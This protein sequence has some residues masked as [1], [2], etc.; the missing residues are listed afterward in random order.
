[1]Q[2]KNT[3]IIVALSLL[4]APFALAMR[5]VDRFFDEVQPLLRSK[6]WSCHGAEKQKGD[7]RLD[8]IQAIRTGGE[9]GPAFFVG[10]PARSLMIQA[11]RHI[12]DDLEMPPKEPLTESQIRT[13]EEW[14]LEGAAWPAPVR[15]LFEDEPE[16]VS[17]LDEDRGTG[18]L[19]TKDVF[20]GRAALRTGKQL[21]SRNIPGWRFSIREN[22]AGGEYRYI[23]FAWKKRG[24]G[25]LIFEIPNDG[26]WRLQ[27]QTNGAWVAGKN[28]SEWGAIQISETAP[29]EW[30]VVTRDLW[31][32][33]GDWKDFTFTGMSISTLDGGEALIDS[34]ILGPTVESLDAYHPGRGE[35]ALS[36]SMASRGIAHRIGDAWTDPENP[37][38]KK[39]AGKRLDLWSLQKPLPVTPPIVKND[40]WVRTPVDRFILANLDA[41]GIA[42]SPEA[43]RRTLIRRL[44]F[45]LLG[46]PPTPAEV[47]AFIEEKSPQ[48]YEE[49]VEKLLA[50]KRYGQRWGR[51]WLDV[52][53]YADTMGFERDEFRPE[54]YR[55]RDYVIR[56]FNADKPYDVFIKEQ[57]AGDEMVDSIDPHTSADADRLIATG[58]MRLGQYDSTAALF[59]EDG[60]GR[61]QLQQDLA[62]TT[63]SAFLGLTIACANC[64]DHKY[65][66]IL[67]ADHFRLRAYFASVKF[68]DDIVIDT[69]ETLQ[70][71]EQHNAA[72]KKQIES[73]RRDARK[74]L[75]AARENVFERRSKEIPTR[76]RQ[77]FDQ[78]ASVIPK[79]L[80]Q[81]LT[82][83]R[84]ARLNV[85]DQDAIKSMAESEKGKYTELTNRLEELKNSQR[86]P[87]NALAMT[88]S[89][90]K[91]PVT[92]VFYQ[93][94][95][96]Q[97]KEA[98]EPGVPSALDPNPASVTPTKSGN[99]TG[100]RTALATWI[101][102]PEN[103][104]TARVMVNR[105]W[106]RHFGQGIVA[107]PN[108]FGY[109]GDRPSNQPLLDWLAGEFV[110]GGWSM[111]QMHRV[112]LLSS[113]YRQVSRQEGPGMA[114]DA[115][116]TLFWRQ[117]LR[118]HDAETLRDSMLAVSGL[119]LPVDGGSPLWPPVA[120]ELLDA[121]PSILETHSDEAARKRLEGW[122]ADPV[123]KTN[124]R[125]MFLIQKRCLPVPFLQPF[126]LQD[127]AISCA[128]RT[129]TTV[130]PQ[131]LTL[132]N[133]DLSA[134]TSRAFADRIVAGVG[135]N[136]E[137][138]VRLSVWLALGRAPEAEELST[139]M[140]F[141]NRN[142]ELYRKMPGGKDSRDPRQRA[143]V[144][145][146]RALLNVNEFAYVD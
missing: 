83:G 5:P 105:I 102:S 49:C 8:S 139:G 138:R 51:Y 100:R 95:Y 115:D 117:N 143:L 21:L 62:N 119:L 144:D 53:R 129:T 137:A 118:R 3:S 37:V 65:D 99:S 84:A 9:N 112:I 130:A 47:K 45:D 126:D 29:K 1:M 89:G 141:L 79:N 92:R 78:A 22:P 88:D 113:T 14:V 87:A 33:G 63:G 50:D 127:M 6:C 60:R 34:V 122:Y 61:D 106:Q 82:P 146:C 109:S 43:D 108:D 110:R 38:T 111:K 15:V 30:T 4:T 27:N 125:T 28:T 101:A 10:D 80:K 133:S 114:I 128:A 12:H 103:P 66:P 73:I 104:L 40:S 85:R 54:T 116:N 86:K 23:R 35:S 16:I 41:K 26:Q 57:L 107:T 46:L 142:A 81:P 19:E 72:V 77:Q 64:H 121:Q 134:R 98:V 124:V 24:S 135:A 36:L 13:L 25:G 76:L 48:A 58:Y 120:Q 42:P 52:V 136:A 91:A 96:L 32:D 68:R 55:Y 94:D 2:L 71:I 7:L 74:M 11:V 17:L 132:L 44:Y 56:A 67:Q 131:A 97:P 75:T 39:W 20:Q 93:G 18:T 123:E 59:G 145:W 90:A 69:P 140:A 31:K 70:Q